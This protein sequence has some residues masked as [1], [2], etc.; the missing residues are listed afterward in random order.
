MSL[1]RLLVV[2]ANNAVPGMKIAARSTPATADNN[3]MLPTI[4]SGPS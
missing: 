4:E 1:L 2:D 3:A